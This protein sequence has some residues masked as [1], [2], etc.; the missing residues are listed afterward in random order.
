MKACGEAE[1]ASRDTC[2][3]RLLGG[4]GGGGARWAAEWIP[5]AAAEWSGATFGYV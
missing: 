3:S 1:T 4:G 2:W 5:A